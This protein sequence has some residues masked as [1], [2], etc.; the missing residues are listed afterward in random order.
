M[1]KVYLSTSSTL[2]VL[3]VLLQLLE[4]VLQVSTFIILQVL[5]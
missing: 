2:K 1:L 3:E 5:A 4:I